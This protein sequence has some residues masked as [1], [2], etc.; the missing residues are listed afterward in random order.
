M[1]KPTLDELANAAR[2]GGRRDMDRFLKALRPVVAR[3]A[4]VLTGSPDKA[5]DVVPWVAPSSVP[6]MPS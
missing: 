4:I 6:S 5:E 3:W 2:S 1:A